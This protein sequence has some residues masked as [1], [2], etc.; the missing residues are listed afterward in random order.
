MGAA[1][2]SRQHH[3]RFLEQNE[4]HTIISVFDN[5]KGADRQ[6]ASSLNSR[7]LII[8]LR[9]DKKPMT[10]EL[11]QRYDHP[12]GPGGYAYRRGNFQILRNNN[13]FLCWS[14]QSLQ[15]EHT[16]DGR[17]IMEA[18]MVPNWIGT[19]RG[20]KYEFV[21]LPSDPPDVVSKAF[22]HG[23]Q[24]NSTHT[25]VHV[26]WNGATEV[27][28]WN[29]YKSTEDG[30]TEVRIAS[31][32]REGFETAIDCDGFASFVVVQGIGK[33]GKPLGKSKVITTERPPNM[34]T[35]EVA[36]DLQWLKE[37]KEGNNDSTTSKAHLISFKNPYFSVF[38]FIGGFICTPIIFFLV[39]WIRRR[40]RSAW[41]KK[42][43]SYA[44]IARD[45]DA[46]D[47]DETKL[48][49][50]SSDGHLKDEDSE[51]FQLTDEDS[52]GSGRIGRTPYLRQTTGD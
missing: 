34:D 31:K 36:A 44:A 7:G 37:A 28:R 2:F 13:A 3:A 23:N 6:Q 52:D 16:R 49:D 15:S 29:L 17:M 42:G 43:P 46:A 12:R 47:Y 19:Y 18:R 40:R 14:E 27:S 26:S 38:G 8:A 32:K 51:Q 50:L 9:T 21:G 30:S 39:R 22:S 33:D 5:A 4:T 25:T 20:F 1:N 48:D 10:A 24:A 35:P 45:G 41:H 11:V